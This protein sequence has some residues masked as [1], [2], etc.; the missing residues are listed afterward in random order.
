MTSELSGFR[1]IPPSFRTCVA[2]AIC[3]ATIGFCL[4]IA[5]GVAADT[6]CNSV[7]RENG[8][9]RRKEVKEFLRLIFPLALGSELF[10]ES[11]KS[12]AATLNASADSASSNAAGRE[13]LYVVFTATMR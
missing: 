10:Y 8:R 4:T 13:H 6:S 7:W 2:D 3:T 1:T 5:G 9:S 12:L 11:D